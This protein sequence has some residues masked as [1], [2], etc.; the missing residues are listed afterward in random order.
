M[1]I[2]TGL[3][4]GRR[5]HIPNTL[6][7]RPTT[8]RTKESMFSILDARKHILGTLVLDLFGGSV[9]LGFVDISRCAKNLLFVDSDRLNI[10]HID[11]QADDFNFADQI[12]TV[13]SKV[14]QFLDGI[15]LPYD[16]I[17][18]D[19]PYNYRNN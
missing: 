17:F 10:H 16:I 6:N 11:K 1:R 15:P 9:N 2:I 5:I 3:L 8:D 7:V 12:R 4:K 19:P 13:A 14:E 18:S